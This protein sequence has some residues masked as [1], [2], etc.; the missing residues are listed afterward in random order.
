MITTSL[1]V[2][3]GAAATGAILGAALAVAV[4]ARYAK[5][6]AEKALST[7]VD[8]VSSQIET[9]S[10]KMQLT[11]NNAVVAL[12]ATTSAQVST[13]IQ[14]LQTTLITLLAKK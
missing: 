3:A 8:G 14:K 6:V 10:G 2:I 5:T 11:I 1:V 9:V 13:E 12:Q 7:T 4:L